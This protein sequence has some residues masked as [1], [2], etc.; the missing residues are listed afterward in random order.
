MSGDS[1]TEDDVSAFEAAGTLIKLHGDRAGHYALQQVDKMRRG[2][3]QEGAAVWFRITNA[4]DMTTAATA[5]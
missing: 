3:N 2:G 1:F 4:I 5:H